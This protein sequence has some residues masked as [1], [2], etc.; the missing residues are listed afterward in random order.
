VHTITN[1]LNKNIFSKS[2]KMSCIKKK[3]NNNI[4]VGGENSSLVGQV[5]VIGD[6][7][8]IL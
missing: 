6:G 4:T 7:V 5:M 3:I 2:L 8:F 1:K